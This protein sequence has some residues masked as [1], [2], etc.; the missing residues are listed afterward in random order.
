MKRLFHLPALLLIVAA[1][2]AGRAAAAEDPPALIAL[3]GDHARLMRQAHGRVLEEYAGSLALL[4]QEYARGNKLAQAIELVAEIK[5]V[6]DQIE[7]MSRQVVLVSATYGLHSENRVH[8]VTPRL[9]AAMAAHQTE[10]LLDGNLR[11]EL[12][13][14]APYKVKKTLVV[15]TVNRQRKEKTFPEDYRLNFARDL[16]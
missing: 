16:P 15:Y 13:D 5:G 8:D 2:V 3:R 10:I 7:S 14:P 6:I 9:K 12:A 4:K 11:G 1:T